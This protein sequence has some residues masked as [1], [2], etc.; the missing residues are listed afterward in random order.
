MQNKL[1]KLTLLSQIK[2]NEACLDLFNF[3]IPRVVQIRSKNRTLVHVLELFY[4]EHIL[5]FKLKAKQ[6]E[7][8]MNILHQRE[9][10]CYFPTSF[11]KSNMYQSH[12]VKVGKNNS[13]VSILMTCSAQ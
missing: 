7:A 10:L 2:Y 11:G 13:K 4:S 5:C 9:T 3:T 1:I 6:H 8:L 12:T